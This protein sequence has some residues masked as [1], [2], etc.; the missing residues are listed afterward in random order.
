MGVWF[1]LPNLE[2]LTRLGGV[3]LQALQTKIEPQ[4]SNVC[5]RKEADTSISLWS[6]LYGFPDFFS[7]EQTFA[8]K[9]KCI[10]KESRISSHQV[11]WNIMK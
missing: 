11:L 7:Q 1:A 2:S 3:T 6:F 9:G 4:V 10:M 5:E 8:G